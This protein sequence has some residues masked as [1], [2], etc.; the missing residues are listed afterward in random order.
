MV[1]HFIDCQTKRLEIIHPDSSATSLRL[2]MISEC[3]K[4]LDSYYDNVVSLMHTLEADVVDVVYVT[5]SDKDYISK[6]RSDLL[7]V[8]QG[9]VQ[10]W[11][12]NNISDNDRLKQVHESIIPGFL[13]THASRNETSVKILV[14]RKRIFD[15]L[16]LA[17][18]ETKP[19]LLSQRTDE[20]RSV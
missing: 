13:I 2:D 6:L 12:E 14:E 8:A 9:T 20:L 17:T 15:D 7:W 18:R 1:E 3:D 10:N 5:N 16:V 4:F 19:D 11:A